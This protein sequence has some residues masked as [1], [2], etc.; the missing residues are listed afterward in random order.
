[1]ESPRALD[2]FKKMSKVN[3]ITWKTL[4]YKINVIRPKSKLFN[5][6]LKFVLT[7]GTVRKHDT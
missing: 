1:M 2:G 4:K 6:K 5:N 3:M 7:S